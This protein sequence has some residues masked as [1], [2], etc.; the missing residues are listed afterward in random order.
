M[1]GHLGGIRIRRPHVVQGALVEVFDFTGQGMHRPHISGNTDIHVS[2]TSSI[3]GGDHISGAIKYSTID[4]FPQSDWPGS[5][6]EARQ[7]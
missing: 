5:I 1:S 6:P 3:G 7:S 4:P 2:A